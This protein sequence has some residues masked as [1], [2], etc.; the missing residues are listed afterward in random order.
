[1]IR[2][3][4]R[5]A[6]HPGKAAATAMTLLG[7]AGGVSSGSWQIAVI[8]ALVFGSIF[9]GVVLITAFSQPVEGE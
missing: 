7:A 1:M 3:R 5:L 6:A 8:G 2:Y 4:D 9:W